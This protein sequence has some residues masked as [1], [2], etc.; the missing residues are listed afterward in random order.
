MRV[1]SSLVLKSLLVGQPASADPWQ[2]QW[3]AP[4][5]CPSAPQV[6][7]IVAGWRAQAPATTTETRVRARARITA[8]PDGVF[9][10]QLDLI[11]GR[12]V[13]RHEVEATE[14]S[15]L[16]DATALQLAM[17]LGFVGEVGDVPP[18]PPAAEVPTPPPPSDTTPPPIDTT[19]PAVTAPATDREPVITRGDRPAARRSIPLRGALRLQGGAG[20]GRVPRVDGRLGL[21]GALLF[22]RARIDAVV[23]H[24]FLQVQPHPERDGLSLRVWQWT[25]QLRGCWVPQVGPVEL[26][27]CGGLEAGASRATSRGVPI[28]RDATSPFVAGVVAGALAWPFARRFALWVEVSGWLAATQPAF[29]V[30]DLPPWFTTRRAGVDGAVG[31][32]LRLP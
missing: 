29:T 5:G 17:A 10:L 31:L 22:R 9:A 13:T 2:L 7:A 27:V 14:C 23:M 20:T 6:E 26:P 25:G 1:L 19:P 8:R 32:E 4:A 3:S 24:T 18:E 30:Q 15:A 11:E 16:A 21:G 28:R 12:V